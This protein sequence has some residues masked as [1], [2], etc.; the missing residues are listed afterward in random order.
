[1]VLDGG[2][3]LF[4]GKCFWLYLLDWFFNFLFEVIGM[5]EEGCFFLLMV[6]EDIILLFL[7]NEVVLFGDFFID[8]FSLFW[9]ICIIL[10]LFFLFI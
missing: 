9:V 10:V 3:C 7:V 2:C 4:F 1:M 5:L 6:L 8:L